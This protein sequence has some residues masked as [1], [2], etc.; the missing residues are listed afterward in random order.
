M[1]VWRELVERV[2]GVCVDVLC[3]GGAQGGEWHY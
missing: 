3:V 1:G 2:G